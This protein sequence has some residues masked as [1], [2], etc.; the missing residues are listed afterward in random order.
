MAWVAAAAGVR[1][2]ARAMAETLAVPVAVVPMPEPGNE[3]GCVEPPALA[4][5]WI[6]TV[7]ESGGGAMP[8]A[9]VN[10]GV[11]PLV[12]SPDVPAPLTEPGSPPAAG[13]PESDPV[14]AASP[15]FLASSVAEAVPDFA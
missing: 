9:R 11:P 15:A 3:T 5:D 8:G 10:F 4:G 13:A 2:A 12:V 1:T 7:R 14:M 6:G